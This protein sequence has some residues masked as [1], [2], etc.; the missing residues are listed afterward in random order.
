[1]ITSEMILE[2]RNDVEQ[3]LSQKRFSHTLGVE[4]AAVLIGEK[5]LP[6]KLNE[7]RAAALLHDIAKELST[8]DQ[9][10][11]LIKNEFPLND[12]DLKSPQ[13]LH[14]FV[15]PYVIITDFPRFATKEILNATRFHTVG[16]ADMTVFDEIIFIADFVEDTREY[17]ACIDTRNILFEALKSNSTEDNVSE[18]HKV[19]LHVFDFTEQYLIKKQRPLNS[20]MFNARKSIEAKILHY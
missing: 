16:D 18:L 20:R 11:I 19:V 2:L 8:E 12:D 6:S 14:S 9:I 3:R 7:L 4:R 10:E 13:I 15:A 17:D 5:C 1:M